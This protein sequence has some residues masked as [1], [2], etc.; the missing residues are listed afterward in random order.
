MEQLPSS[1]HRNY[2][3][4]WMREIFAD[5]VGVTLSGEAFLLAL[6]RYLAVLVPFEQIS[7]SNRY[8]GNTLRRALVGA[9]LNYFDTPLSVA[10]LIPQDDDRR[11]GKTAKD[12]LTEFREQVLPL[13]AEHAFVHNAN[14][15]EEH[16]AVA[17]LAAKVASEET[18]VWRDQ[19]FRLIPSAIALAQKSSSSLNTY[20]RFRELHGSVESPPA[21]VEGPVKWVFSEEYL[22]SLRP[23]LLGADGKFKVPPLLL[24]GTHQRI[25]FVG[26]TN[27]QLLKSMEQAFEERGKEPWQEIYLFFATDELLR[28]VEYDGRDPRRDRDESEAEFLNMLQQGRWAKRWAI[29]RFHGPPVFASY[30][31]WETRGGRIHVSPALLGTVIGQC[32]ASDHL[33]HQEFPTDHYKKYV[34]HLEALIR[35]ESGTKIVKSSEPPPESGRPVGGR[36]ATGQE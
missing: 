30:W 29:Y 18:L 24:L 21:W 33:W 35:S 36:R 25:A 20:K 11:F 1:P 13:I 31:D 32:P 6:A 7:A 5:A 23:T 26:A 27:W 9:C 28:Q 12:L 14:W 10:D 34:R 16:K 3:Q 19:P 22:P 4:N 8:P 15:V 17:E 2:W